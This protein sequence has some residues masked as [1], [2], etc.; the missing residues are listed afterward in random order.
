MP[1][2]VWTSFTDKDFR[3]GLNAA[4]TTL[5]AVAGLVGTTVE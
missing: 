5:S 3:L 2:D 4:Q 1:L